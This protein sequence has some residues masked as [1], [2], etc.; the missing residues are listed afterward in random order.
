MKMCVR[1]L[2]TPKKVTKMLKNY[3]K[4]LKINFELLKTAHFIFTC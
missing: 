3:T 4:M 2:A 1:Y